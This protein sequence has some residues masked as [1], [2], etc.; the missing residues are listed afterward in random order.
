MNAMGQR[1]WNDDR[2]VGYRTSTSDRIKGAALTG[3]LYVAV[4]CGFF[5]TI[6]TAVHVETRAPALTVVELQS[7]SEAREVMPE[8]PDERRAET[9]KKEA[10]PQSPAVDKPA[11]LPRPPLKPVMPANNQPQS[12]AQDPPNA[13][14]SPRPVAAPLPPSNQGLKTDTWESEV[15]A[16][17]I[18]YR[19]YPRMAEFRRQQ[20]VPWIRFVLNREGKVISTQLEQSSGFLDLDREAV[21]LPKRAQPFPAP[22]ANRPGERFGL[23][24]PVEFFLD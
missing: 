8:P 10:E 2:Q 24:V 22:P 17:L 21:S 19:R 5:I 3:I 15:L 7:L 11:S 20:G 18:R 12:T 6:R 4:V 23:I 14:P 13:A 1:H 9:Q 16:R